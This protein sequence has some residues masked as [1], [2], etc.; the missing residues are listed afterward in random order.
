V[1]GA[2]PRV[3]RIAHISDLHVLDWTGARPLQFL[4]KRL[5][6]LANL[7][8]HR[9]GAHPLHVAL[10]LADR[11]AQPD[12]DHVCV[13]GDLTNLALDGEFARARDV[14][15]R[16]GGPDR[17]TVVPGNHDA[18]TV[19]AARSG[20]AERWFGDLQGERAAGA[21]RGHASYPF[22]RDLLGGVR[23][24][25]LSSAVPSLPFC[26]FGHIG[27][28]QVD[29]WRALAAG[30]PA[31]TVVRIVLVHHNLHR[32]PGLGK[33]LAVLRDAPAFA[34]AARERRVDLVLHGHSHQPFQGHLAGAPPI[35]VVGCGSSTWHRDGKEYA[36][37]NLIAIEDGRITSIRAFRY[38]AASRLF[39]ADGDDLYARALDPAAQ[40]PFPAP[41]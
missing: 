1:I 8:G 24:Y 27:R 21:D 35:A 12:I 14:L 22:A 13:T 10:A 20:R 2:R 34:A 11:L 3:V 31:S 38:R 33:R 18:Y 17:V 19:G 15:G 32:E 26:A 39:E 29:K 41:R 25:G 4:G 9:R 16:I 6:G 36:R 7:I 37:F 28:R 40:L 23:I 5:T 30:E